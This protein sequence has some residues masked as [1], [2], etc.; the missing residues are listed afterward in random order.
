MSEFR[1]L[2]RLAPSAAV[3]EKKLAALAA[4][5]GAAASGLVERAVLEAEAR[6]SLELAARETARGTPSEW[7]EAWPRAR[8]AVDPQAPL[9][10]AALRA[11]HRALMG[12][13]SF[14]DRDLPPRGSG[15]AAAPVVFIA[16]RLEIL[17]QWMQVES[18]RELKPAQQGALVLARLVEI[19]PFGEADGTVARLATSHVI[20]RAG[21][22]P[23]LLNAGDAERLD[24][25]IAA[26]FRLDTEPLTA[27][28]D[29]AS[30]RTLDVMI[31]ALET[32]RG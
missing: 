29:E 20:V 3:K 6:G 24:A 14:R 7:V 23:P 25:T 9:T 13:D 4:E 21:G 5:R 17:E 27:L 22:R 15:P 28:L 19:A 1:R 2:M 10:V 12:S 31:S 8:Q 26:A 16:S 32:A 30:E 18:G 11:W